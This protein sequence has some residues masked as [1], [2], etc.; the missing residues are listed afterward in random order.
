MINYKEIKSDRQWRA[1]TGLTEEKFHKL[2]AHFKVAYET[3]NEISLAEAQVN[4]NKKFI[5]GTYEDCLFYVLFQLKNGLSYDSLGFLIGTEAKVARD[6]FERY[7][8]LLLAVFEGLSLVPKRSFESLEE[9]ESYFSK[10]ETLLI[11]ASEQS[12]YRPCK[13]EEQQEAYSAKKRNI[14][15][16][17]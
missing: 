10:V 2:A 7:V 15:I 16:K 4:L 8:V 11:D 9:F 1:T 12:I 14:H 5:L 6:N 13:E 3:K 17:S